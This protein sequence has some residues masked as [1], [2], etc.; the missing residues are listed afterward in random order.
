[1]SRSEEAAIAGGPSG[2]EPL[3]RYARDREEDGANA[4]VSAFG[5]PPIDGV[6]SD[7]E[8]LYAW[9]DPDALDDLIESAGSDVRLSAVIWGYPVVITGAEVEIYEPGVTA[10][11]QSL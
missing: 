8:S 5:E 2:P 10:R 7:A 1:M 11:Q 3:V 4:V 9:V 6:P